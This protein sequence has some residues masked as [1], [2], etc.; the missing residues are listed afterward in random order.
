MNRRQFIIAT[1]LLCLPVLSRTAWARED[2]WLVIL[3]DAIQEVE[4]GG[5]EDPS[6]ALGDQGASLG[7]YQIKRAYFEDA[8]QEMGDEDKQRPYT[9]VRV[10]GFARRVVI[11]YWKRYAP[12]ALA[13][14]D[15]FT[16]AR[17]HN[18]GPKGDKK[19]KTAPYARKV[20]V[21]MK[22]RQAT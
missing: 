20:L 8:R 18:G 1:C 14:K 5:E 4:T 12:D 15:A 7:P 21:A 22:R 6:E 9:D 3:L 13:N 16:L 2:R 17:I 19:A 11:A 10:A